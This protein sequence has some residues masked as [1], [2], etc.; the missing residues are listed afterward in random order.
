MTLFVPS[1]ALV[2]AGPCQEAQRFVLASSE[3]LELQTHVQAVL[4]LPSDVSEYETRYGDAS[5]G[6]AMKEVFDAMYR[7]RE[8]ASRYG[9]PK[10]LRAS[11]VENPHFLVSATRPRNDAFSATVWTLQRAQQN[12]SELAK[13]LKLIPTIARGEAPAEAVSG[14]KSLF[15]GQ[16][17][18][19]DKMHQTVKRLNELIGEFEQI[20][21]E[22]DEAQTQMR[23]Y[24]DRSSKTRVNLDQEIGA[25]KLNI[26]KLEQ[27][28]DAAYN[29]WR[30][31]TIS[32][33]IVPAGIGIIGIVA[34]VVL[35]VP[36]GGAS[37][38]VGTA[39]TGGAVAASAAALGAA[40]GVARSDYEDLVSKV[41][42]QNAFMGKR[43]AY[44]T[45]LGALDDLMRFSLP[46]SS[47]VI[48]QL[49][50]VRDAWTGSIR[51]LTARVNDLST[52]NLSTS[53]WLREQEMNAASGHWNTLDAS[54]RGF[55]S[56]SLIDA[57]LLAFGDALPQDDAGWLERFTA[58]RAA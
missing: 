2:K 19:V 57:D 11:L 17:Q 6:S 8:T 18:V 39:V 24:T 35:A 4:A 16:G 48:D 53:P 51:E 50:A 54:L 40:A 23:I 29:K 27:S 33:C 37:F 41:E 13:T 52:G 38:A 56:G 1:A 32:A 12:A 21:R 34:M 25:L 26:A 47:G 20:E 44:R 46:A 43:V 5:S 42:Q 55:L 49:G 58:S 28:R 36:T 45:D 31:L 10:Q 22:L 15:L 3:W 30:D 7:L 14:I 9:S